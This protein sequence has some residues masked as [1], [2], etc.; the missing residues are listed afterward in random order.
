MGDMEVEGGGYGANSDVTNVLAYSEKFDESGTWAPT[1]SVS[2]SA[3]A[4]DS[5]E[6]MRN[7]DR[8][9]FSVTSSA[10][11]EVAQII[12][13]TATTRRTGSVWVRVDSS[14]D[15]GAKLLVGGPGDTPSVRFREYDVSDLVDK[16]WV[17]V[18]HTYEDYEDVGVETGLIVRVEGTST[19]GSK[20][21]VLDVW[22]GQLETKE[23]P[24]PYVPTLTTS[25]T[26]LGS[27]LKNTAIPFSLGTTGR[28]RLRARFPYEEDE[29]EGT[30][31]MRLKGLQ[32]TT[33]V[34]IDVRRDASGAD[35]GRI[36]YEVWEDTTCRAKFVS[37]NGIGVGSG[38]GPDDAAEARIEIGWDFA[39]DE[40]WLT[41]NDVPAAEETAPDL[42][43]LDQFSVDDIYFG[44]DESSQDQPDAVLGDVWIYSA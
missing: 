35:N 40:A 21:V 23:Y 24:G 43:H 34:F 1:G 3:D 16:G 15:T 30:R 18:F 4:A 6:G 8:I 32:G 20:N 17:R 19:G 11:A 22:G 13:G 41:V 25:A 33:D 26:A 10:P 44:C 42:D 27:S 38:K 29:G 5:P 39:N 9:T 36:V 28:V 12:S 14:E 37:T 7:A 2:V 31:L